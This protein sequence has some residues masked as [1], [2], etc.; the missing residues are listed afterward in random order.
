MSIGVMPHLTVNQ[1]MVLLD[2]YRGTFD[3]R[4]HL[5]TVDHDL[6]MLIA[7]EYIEGVKIPTSYT[8]TM[9]GEDRV[10]MMLN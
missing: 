8:P 3:W 7:K 9:L 1:A 6:K 4:R 2:I 5:G 10:K